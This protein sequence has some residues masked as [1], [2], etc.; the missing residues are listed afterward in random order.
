MNETW[1][2][3]VQVVFN[4]G[5]VLV[6]VGLPFALPGCVGYVQGDHGGVVV[7]EPDFFWFGGYGD[8]GYG[9]GYGYRG[10]NSRWGR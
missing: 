6:L 1:S 3:A 8:G 2:R 10:G 9:R 5:V 7:A 4:L